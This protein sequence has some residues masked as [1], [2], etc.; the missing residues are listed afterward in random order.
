MP[1]QQPLPAPAV[2]LLAGV[3]MGGVLGI[4]T[5]GIVMDDPTPETLI[6]AAGV[7]AVGGGAVGAVIG[8]R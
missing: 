4:A 1:Q 3:T 8:A 7:G 6:A 2:G 5:A